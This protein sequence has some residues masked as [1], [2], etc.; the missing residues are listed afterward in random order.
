MSHPELS[1]GGGSSLSSGKLSKLLVSVGDATCKIRRK[2]SSFG[3]AERGIGRRCLHRMW[4]LTPVWSLAL[5]VWVLKTAR[6][7]GKFLIAWVSYLTWFASIFTLLNFL[8]FPFISFFRGYDKWRLV[9]MFMHIV[10]WSVCSYVILMT[11]TLENLNLSFSIWLISLRSIFLVP[12]LWLVA[13]GR[14]KFFLYITSSLL[15]CNRGLL[16]SFLTWTLVKW[17]LLKRFYD[18]CWCKHRSSHVHKKY[19][20]D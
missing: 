3:N 2:G 13:S 4:W 7:H 6:A 1:S 10:G 20:T 12:S 15:I 5:I 18:L 8:A 14:I 19:N 17:L 16:H 11:M 9:E